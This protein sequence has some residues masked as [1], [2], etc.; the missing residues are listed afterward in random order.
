V[1]LVCSFFGVG[2]LVVKLIWRHLTKVR[3]SR[4]ST[5]SDGDIDE[6]RIQHENESSQV[7]LEEDSP[8]RFSI[9]EISDDEGASSDGKMSP[10]QSP[11]RSPKRKA[12]AA[13]IA[14][15]DETS[16]DI[17]ETVQHNI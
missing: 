5:N 17:P 2:L 1:L 7:D 8:A 16:V 15:V 11:K 14:E 13:T 4:L 12:V 9:G 10:Q 3:W 6:T